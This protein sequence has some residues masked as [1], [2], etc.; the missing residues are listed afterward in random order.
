MCV[1]R[2]IIAEKFLQTCLIAPVPEYNKGTGSVISVSQKKK[3]LKQRRAE[4]QKAVDELSVVR[5]SLDDAYLRFDAMTDPG[6]MDA[7]IFEISALRA[8]YDCAVRAVKSL[9]L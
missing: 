9:Y 6:L 1:R 7:C 3:L 2:G 4:L 5:G 8:R